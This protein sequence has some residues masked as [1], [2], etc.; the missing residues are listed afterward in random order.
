MLP[1]TQ[2]RH[3][4]RDLR[5]HEERLQHLRT[6]ISR[7]DDEA[8]AHE[9]ILELG[10]DE[11]LLAALGELSGEPRLLDRLE[12]DPATFLR[13]RG[14]DLPPESRID[15]ERT[16]DRIVASVRVVAGPWEFSCVWD[17][18]SGFGLFEDTRRWP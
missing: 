1:R 13:E 9:R 18:A 2:L 16:D 15:V 3:L 17:S 4:A 14:I 10:R 5:A 7:M 6:Q 8:R 11:R 12:A